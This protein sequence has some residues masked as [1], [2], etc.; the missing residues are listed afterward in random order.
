MFHFVVC[1]FFRTGVA[2]VG[3]YS[4]EVVAVFASKA[5]HLGGSTAYYR[6]FQV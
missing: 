3:T 6:T 4:A 2:G 1:T 5:H